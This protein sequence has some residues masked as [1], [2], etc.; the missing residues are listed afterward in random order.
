MKID[1]EDY[2]IASLALRLSG[3]SDPTDEHFRRAFDLLE[4]AKDARHMRDY[5]D[6]TKDSL[7]LAYVIERNNNRADL[8]SLCGKIRS[9]KAFRNAIIRD[10]SRLGA[11]SMIGGDIVR[12]GLISPWQLKALGW[13]L[14]NPLGNWKGSDEEWRDA[15]LKAAFTSPPLWIEEK[16]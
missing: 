2:W 13:M 10:F 9:V 11:S 16:K 6:R 12:M 8:P 14:R 15:A 1:Q 5:D 3:G 4:A 7:P